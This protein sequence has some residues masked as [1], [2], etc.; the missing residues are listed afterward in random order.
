MRGLLPT[1]FDDKLKS[2]K[3]RLRRIKNNYKHEF[4]SAKIKINHF[5]KGLNNKLK[6]YFKKNKAV[7]L[8]EEEIEEKYGEIL[9]N[10]LSSIQLN[11][12]SNDAP[13]VS[14]II[15]NRNGYEH[16]KRLFKDFKENIQYPSYEIIIVDNSSTDDSINFLEELSETLPLTIIKNDENKSFSKANNEASEIAK[17]EYLLLLNNDVQPLYGWLNQMMHTALKSNEIGATGAKLIYPYCST[18]VYNKNN[19]FKVQHKGIAFKEEDGFI[20]PYNL[21]DDDPYS[22]E[23]NHEKETA[24]VTGAALLVK[25]EKY[26]EVD[27]LDERYSYGYEDVDFCLKLLKKGHKNKYCP[28]AQLFHYEFGTQE[29]NKRNEVKK[30]RVN[31]RKL[32]AQKWNQ[33]L[34]KQLFIDKIE[35]NGLFCEKPLKFAFTVTENSKNTSSGDYFTALEFGESLKKSGY[36]IC[37]LSRR[38]PE[39]WYDIDEDVDILVALLDIYDPH[40]IKSRNKSLIKIAWCRN[41][42]DRWV[43]NPGFQDY[44]LIFAPSETSCN[45]IKEKI[46]REVTLLPLATNP[47]RF[48]PKVQPYS[49]YSCDYCFTGSYWDDPRKIVDMLD[50]ESIPYKFKLYGQ[51]WE[52]IGK[53]DEYDQ[54]FLSYFK[55]PELYASTKIVIDDANR[56]TRNYGAV[57]SRVY[58]ALASGTMVI[59]NGEIGSKETFKGKL[60]VFSSKKEL[61]ELITYYMENEEARKT[62]IK[63]LHGFV[64]NNCTYDIRASALKD[65]LKQHFLKTKIAIKIPAPNWNEV[66]EW[67]D[68]HV[69][70]GLKK[71]FEKKSCAVLLQVL[72]EWDSNEDFYCDAV[73]V[74]R[75]LSRYKPKPHHYNIMWN[76]S[77]PEEVDIEEY[78]EYD[79]VLIASEYWAQKIQKE[80]DVPVEAML[81][82]TD[83][84]LFYPD[85]TN[86]YEYDI[87]FVGNSRKVFRKIIKDLLPTSYNL[88]VYGK[89]WEKFINKKYIKGEY[90][91]NGELRKAYSSCK[92]LLNDHWD[93]MRENGFIS[94]RVFDG[95]ASGAFIISD[96]VKG[97]DKVFKDALVTYE[98][99]DKLTCLIKNYLNDKKERVEKSNNGLKSIKDQHIYHRRAER[100][101]E[102]INLITKNKIH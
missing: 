79:H 33:W 26:L 91:P 44:D 47:G 89:D 66:H 60:P 43:S 77:H 20:K 5:N 3:N 96:N 87:L 76:I 13:L 63:E 64:L 24:A 23:S 7:L 49:E 54:G 46:G 48:N 27:G 61:N 90:I 56:V 73:I 74:L 102:I 92:I 39:D 57:N 55:L 40:K 99:S 28:N 16:L 34:K 30:R 2:S 6:E 70:L 42:F 4:K 38:G 67:G 88:A 98:D 41:W 72:P 58:D 17:G 37:F 68:Y 95:F 11:H 18:S 22:A 86:K 53:F 29:K 32:F 80:A 78:N 65:T 35:N 12:F 93:D 62:K 21:K 84:E 97:V 52:K 50:P 45:Y 81:Q 82:C 69:A 15:L 36:D 8:S 31:N 14:I 83:P 1:K 85:Y 75:G 101:L 51:N 19:S 100:I 94:N 59:T 71:E 10:N 9:S 25:K